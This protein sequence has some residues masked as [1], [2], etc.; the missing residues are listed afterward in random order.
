MIPSSQFSFW[1]Q[2]GMWVACVGLTFAVGFASTLALNRMRKNNNEAA[3]TPAWYEANKPS[4]APPAILFPI[5]WSVLFALLGTSLFLTVRRQ[6]LIPTQVFATMIG[7]Y[8]ANLVL[9]FVWT[10]TFFGMR[11]FGVAL[12]E[13]VMML[14][15][16]IIIIVMQLRSV[17]PAC[18]G[19]ALTVVPYVLWLLYAFA[20]TTHFVLEAHRPQ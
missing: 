4:F 9:I 5:A 18:K 20:L 12:A 11:K 19:A 17:N 13:I 1:A 10:P 16:G 2:V 14:M 3:F 15:V 7:L 6:G 8:I